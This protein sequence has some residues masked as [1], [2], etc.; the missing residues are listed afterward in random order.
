[1]K[2]STVFWGVL[3]IV[4]GGLF[5]LNN[6]GVIFFNWGVLWRL[7]PIVLVAWGLSIIFG[8]EPLRWYVVLLMI[9]IIVFMV[10]GVVLYDW[11]ESRN[12][13]AFGEANYQDFS[14]GFEGA[15][16]RARLEFDGGAG[17]FFI[18]GTTDKLFTASTQLSFGKYIL[19]RDRSGEEERLRF[20]MTGRSERWHFFR[21]RNRAE[22]KL[23]PNPTWDLDADVGAATVDFD[24][25]PFKMKN[26]KI[27]GGAASFKIKLG[28]R[29][30][31]SHLDIRAG[32][33]SIEIEVPSSVGC[34]VIANT[35]LSGRKIIGFEKV[36][37]KTYQTAD[38]ERALKK[39]YI[40]I[41]AGVSNVR[42][43]R[44]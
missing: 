29:A 38:F 14:E 35:K 36:G 32:A 40:D 34:E 44:Y 18:E 33:S 28:D 1:M 27:D 4:L 19:D 17:K 16:Q 15:V 21:V 8:K 23:N 11:Y 9:F 13:F 20:H 12:E 24:L 43:E 25:S 30:D 31:E 42:V 26:V 39:I 2:L 6:L 10:G 5:L 22:I 41:A 7:W 37:N 3:F